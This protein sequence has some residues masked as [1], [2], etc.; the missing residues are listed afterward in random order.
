MKISSDEKI[1][2]KVSVPT[3]KLLE[4]EKRNKRRSKIYYNQGSEENIEE[5][6]HKDSAS[7]R[8]GNMFSD[9]KEFDISTNHTF[10]FTLE[11]F[12]NLDLDPASK[13]R[14]ALK[15]ILTDDNE[16][17]VGLVKRDKRK[18]VFSDRFSNHPIEEPS[19][20]NKKFKA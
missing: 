10:K 2:K 5:N 1:S 4:R 3:E 9:A 13:T 8:K 16:I 7:A 12:E 11:L 17:T 14:G 6:I 20:L 18:K 15:K 19:I